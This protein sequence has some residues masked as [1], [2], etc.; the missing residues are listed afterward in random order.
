MQT[1][2]LT[3]RIAFFLLLLVPLSAGALHAQSFGVAAQGTCEVGSCTPTPLP[4][5][6]SANLPLSFTFTLPN[7]DM[8]FVSD[9]VFGGDSDAAGTTLHVNIVYQVTYQGNTNSLAAPSSA[10]TLNLD[11]YESYSTPTTSA[12]YTD[13]LIGAF[14]PSV[15]PDSSVSVCWNV[16]YCFG[17]VVPYAAFNMTGLVPNSSDNGSMNFHETYTLTFGA[18]SPVGSYIVI[19]QDAPIAVQPPTIAGVVDAASFTDL[20]APGEL[21]SIFGNFLSDGTIQGAATL[22][23]GSKL[24]DSTAT[25]NGTPVPLLYVSPSQINFQIPFETPVGTAQVVVTTAAGVSNSFPITLQAAAPSVFQ[26]NGN[27]AVVENADF[28]LNQSNNGA[29]PG[30]FIITFATGQG[31]VSNQP[32]DG[33]P[34]PSTAPFAEVTAPYSATINGENAPVLFAGLA[35]GFVGLL[36]V[37]IT[38]PSDLAPGTYPLLITIGGATSTSTVIDVQ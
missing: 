14:S 30:S 20:M 36:Q 29:V 25:V 12:N 6:G 4:I 23:L 2:R 15:A 10:D 9:G 24:V 17:P 26:Y 13:D 31:A 37:N 22:P 34:G 16:A 7:G 8:Y 11:F 1:P 18:N 33:A 27:H 21:A 32:A 38:V 28:T 3:D 19:G 35:P 5:G